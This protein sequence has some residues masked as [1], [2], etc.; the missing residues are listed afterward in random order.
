MRDQFDMER[1]EECEMERPGHNLPTNIKELLEALR[2][3]CVTLILASGEREPHVRIEAVI[4]NLLLV[5]L[6][7]QC[8]SRFKFVDIECIC[9]VIT[10]CE[11]IL[12][13]IFRE[14]FC[15]RGSEI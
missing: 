5:K 6:P 11:E 12:N 13:T 9:A 7:G 1:R 10:N 2:G 14:K 4:G 8:C 3:Q 15:H